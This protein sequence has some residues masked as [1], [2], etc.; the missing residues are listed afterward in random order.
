MMIKNNVPCARLSRL[1][2][3]LVLLNFF[4]ACASFRGPGR[5]MASS[6]GDEQDDSGS[7]SPTLSLSGERQVIRPN[8]SLDFDWPVDEA[9][10]TRGFM[11]GSKS[12]WGVD[13]ANTRGTPIMA[14]ER[15]TVIYTGRGFHGYGNLIVIEHNNE[16]ATLYSHLNSITAKEGETVER[17]TKIGTMGR[18]GHATGVHLHFEIRRN[19]QPVN[20]LAYLPE[21]F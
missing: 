4:S 8:E 2:F 13:L 16:W 21:G 15:G 18:T 19:R 6:G 20:P 1:V 9:R 7:S 11:L 10:M 12:H 3:F 5:Y 17:G 14:A